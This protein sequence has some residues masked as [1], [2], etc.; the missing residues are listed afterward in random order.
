[1]SRRTRSQW[2]FD[3]AELTATRSTCPRLFVGALVVREGRVQ[4]MGYNGPPSGF[5]HCN[6]DCDCFLGVQT[7]GE[8]HH[9]AC[10]SQLPCRLSIHAEQNALAF[11]ARYGFA[12]DGCD[13]YITHAPCFDC[14]KLIIQ[15]GISVV[16]FRQPFRDMS[17]VSLLN[18]A[19]IMVTSH[20]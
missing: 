13:L 14:A 2:L 17:G 4:G 7:N 10:N 16:H 18:S 11:A 20:G 1:M 19:N 9:E 12:T 3:I 6:H 15:A 5:P 8:G